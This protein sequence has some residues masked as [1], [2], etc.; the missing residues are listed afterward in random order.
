RQARGRNLSSYKV[1]GVPWATCLAREMT[2]GGTAAA[3]PAPRVQARRTR[4]GTFRRAGRKSN[5]ANK[6]PASHTTPYMARSPSPARAATHQ[7]RW[8]LL[9]SRAASQAASNRAQ[10]QRVKL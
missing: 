4:P 2:E 5:T 1:G 3:I 8:G 9:F 7:R 10:S 6:A